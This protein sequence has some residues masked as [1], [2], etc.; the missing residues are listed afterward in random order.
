MARR[1]AA[2]RSAA[3]PP[4]AVFSQH[5]NRRV[6]ISKNV[7]HVQP[8][9]NRLPASLV[10][11]ASATHGRQHRRADTFTEAPAKQKMKVH[12]AA[13]ASFTAADNVRAARWLM[14]PL[15]NNDT[16]VNGACLVRYRHCF[17]VT[18]VQ[19]STAVWRAAAVAVERPSVPA[20][21]VRVPCAAQRAYGAR[22]WRGGARKCHPLPP[23][24]AAPW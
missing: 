9:L 4:H 15:P 17:C 5:A 2:V 23:A 16:V 18:V 24:G 21:G 14:L 12:A 10:P 13:P 22:A 11:S 7:P 1:Q 20:A 8:L 3:A 19:R 6:R